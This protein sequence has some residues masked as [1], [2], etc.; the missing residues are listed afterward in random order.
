MQDRAVRGNNSYRLFLMGQ[1]VMFLP[2]VP[3]HNCAFTVTELDKI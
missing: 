3:S 1:L 2:F